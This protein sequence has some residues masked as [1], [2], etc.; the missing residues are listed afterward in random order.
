MAT[1]WPARSTR[2]DP[3]MPLPFI[4]RAASVGRERQRRLRAQ[5]LDAVDVGPL[6][7]GER[8]RSREDRRPGQAGRQR[9]TT[10][11]SCS[12]TVRAWIPT[13]GARSQRVGHVLA[14]GGAAAARGRG[15]RRGR[16]TVGDEDADEA[17]LG[18]LA[19]GADRA[20]RVWDDSLAGADPL[21]VAKVL[22]AAVERE[23]PGSGAVRRAVLRC[24]QRGHRGR[25]RR[26]P[27][28]AARRRR[29]AP[30]LRRRGVDRRPSSASSRA[31]S[32]RCC[33]SGP[34]RC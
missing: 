29:Q 9:S 25:A 13:R 7:R 30:R 4:R 24:G 20:V 33:G 23:Q 18:C 31:A 10:S 17:L 27:R 14:R 26:A 15:R 1:A 32:S 21:A 28:D 12:T 2:P 19:R 8:R 3:E 5:L 34:R 22:A 11:S 16:G 6:E